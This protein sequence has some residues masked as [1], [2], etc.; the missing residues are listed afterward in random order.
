MPESARNRELSTDFVGIEGFLSTSFYE[1]AVSQ[2]NLPLTAPVAG[3]S[4][5][6]KY[7]IKRQ[8]LRD[9]KDQVHRL[10]AHRDEPTDIAPLVALVPWLNTFVTAGKQ[11]SIA[12]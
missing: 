1:A 12:R 5:G 9:R 10:L 6:H 7:A 4:A 8:E 11:L 3:A 2:L